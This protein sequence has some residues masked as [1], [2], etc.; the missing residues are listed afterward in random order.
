MFVVVVP[1]TLGW[2]E[3][4]LKL[5][6]PDAA[7]RLV[8]NGVGGTEVDRLTALSPAHPLFSLSVL[9]GSFAKHGTVLD[10][11]LHGVDGDF[12]LLDHDCY[13][14]DATLLERIDWAE[15]E[16]VGAV[17]QRGF[18]TVNG[19]SGLVFPRTHFLALRGEKLRTLALRH[20]LS[21]EKATT[22]PA[23]VASLLAEVGIGD[24]NF[25]PP[26]MPFYDTLQ[27]LMAVAFAEGLKVR[28][29]TT[30]E[31]GICHVGGTARAIN[32]PGVGA[33]P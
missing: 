8:A 9:P 25:P 32:Q 31:D 30:A 23:R 7:V 12:A 2:L 5:L 13:L 28:W 22:T 18:V 26:H 19:A 24:D 33:R 4:C 21:C 1:G 20:G 14:F 16:F 6:P 11:L 29:L 3:P 27:L 15:N 17:H 10:L